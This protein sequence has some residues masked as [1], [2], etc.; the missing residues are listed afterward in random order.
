MGSAPLPSRSPSSG[1]RAS[2]WGGLEASV[3]PASSPDGRERRQEVGREERSAG[4]SDGG[5]GPER[6]RSATERGEA[7]RVGARVLGESGEA[8]GG[9]RV[10]TGPEARGACGDNGRRR[11]GPG[12]RASAGRGR[13]RGARGAGGCQPAASAGGTRQGLGSGSGPRGPARVWSA[14]RS[15]GRTARPGGA[16]PSAHSEAVLASHWLPRCRG[17]GSAARKKCNCVKK[18]SPG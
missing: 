9:G 13:R 18:S 1:R 17:R 14:P 15:S 11:P 7:A 8:A 5:A 12:V 3:S 2:G 10:C 16:R 4:R 6:A